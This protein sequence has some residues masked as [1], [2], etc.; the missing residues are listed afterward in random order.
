MPDT[1]VSVKK[2]GTGDYTT[3]SS[4][5]AASNVSTGYYKIEIQDA[6]QY[7]ESVNISGATG[8][9]SISNYVWLTVASAYRH[10]GVG[11]TSGHARIYDSSA[12]VLTA[13]DNFTRVEYLD[14][15]NTSGGA[16]HALRGIFSPN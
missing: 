14:I 6:G 7:N 16:G 9:E 5:E 11:A 3:I 4:A 12:T 15:H 13:S 10:S 2:D 1:T 8:T